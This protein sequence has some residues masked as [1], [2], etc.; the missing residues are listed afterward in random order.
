MTLSVRRVTGLW[1]I[2]LAVSAAAAAWA[3]ETPPAGG[4]AGT[5]SDS[6]AEKRPLPSP[7]SRPGVRP[8][9]YI[10][11]RVAEMILEEVD[12]DAQQEE[13]FKALMSEAQKK[14]TDRM[15]EVREKSDT[16]NK[17]QELREQMRQARVEG[18]AARIDELRQQMRELFAPQRIAQAEME[19]DLHEGI[20]KILRPDQLEAFEQ[21]WKETKSGGVRRSLSASSSRDLRRAVMALGLTNDQRDKINRIFDEFRKTERSRRSGS[22]KDDAAKNEEI[23]GVQSLRAQIEEVLTQEQKEK[24]EQFL[25]QRGPGRRTGAGPHGPKPEGAGATG[26][27]GSPTGSGEDQ[28]KE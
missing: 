6:G 10:S 19:K 28:R 2:A 20:L 17:I 26:G 8:E 13:Q 11:P 22:K 12:I 3:Q 27:S 21:G 9:V 23:K 15:R 25:T 5:G 14:F 16:L 7:P 24:L 1:I 18:N 4:A